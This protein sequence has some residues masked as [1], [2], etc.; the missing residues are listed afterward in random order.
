MIKRFLETSFKKGEE[1]GPLYLQLE[2]EII[3]LICRGILKPGQALPSSRELA[4]SLQLNRKTVVATYEELSSQGWVETRDR[5]GV[6]ISSH[7]PDTSVR[8]ISQTR[9]KWIGSR[10]PAYSMI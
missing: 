6:Y 5:S 7:L 9:K 3:Q 2:S 1:H 8:S 4:Q 10:Q